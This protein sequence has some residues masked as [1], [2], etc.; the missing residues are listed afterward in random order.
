MIN[1]LRVV[2]TAWA[3]RLADI[4]APNPRHAQ[5]MADLL[6]EAEASAEVYE[7][8]GEYP[9]LPP[10][11]FGPTDVPAGVERDPLQRGSNG[12]HPVRSTSE[13][14]ESAALRLLYLGDP[15]DGLSPE[16]RE[17]AAQFRVCGD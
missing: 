1:Q 11:R 14:L 7:P 16:L 13:L 5:V 9:D 8:L 3:D 4:I 15:R 10:I 6:A 17:R 12:G 2:L